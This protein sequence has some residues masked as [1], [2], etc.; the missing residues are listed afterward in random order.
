MEKKDRLRELASNVEADYSPIKVL[1][2]I[3]F[4]LLS[5]LAFGVFIGL[6]IIGGIAGAGL[7]FLSC[8]VMQALLIKSLSRFAI[9]A[10]FES[11]ALISPIIFLKP[12]FPILPLLFAAVL[13]FLLM[14][15][16]QFSARDALENELKVRFIKISK[17]VLPK[18][19]TAFAVVVAV[20]YGFSFKPE[21][22]FSPSFID[23]TMNLATPIIG[24]FVPDFSPNMSA[25]EFLAVSAR[26]S[27][28]KNGVIN[29]NIMPESIRNQIIN[30]TVEESKN[31]LENSFG[32]SIDLD[33]PFSENARIIF[34]EKIKEVVGMIHPYLISVV[35]SLGVFFLAK[36]A[37]FIV[38]WLVAFFAFIM[39]QVLL[40]TGFAEV[41]LQ[42]RSREIVVMK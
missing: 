11:A 12:G 2:I 14:V 22:F 7:L 40:A 34:T 13:N 35:V 25:R 37:S 33:K 8:L 20:I 15:W 3:L 36:A 24:Y 38:Y 9:G 5:A 6:G 19:F 42:Q 26:Q 21:Y 18:S 1:L 41:T 23:S 29:F 28:A 30:K 17:A 39:Y 31:A 27:L 4:T 16:A 10:I 32:F